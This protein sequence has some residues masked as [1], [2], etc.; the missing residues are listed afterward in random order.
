MS[1]S[2]ITAPSHRLASAER[3]L[4]HDWLA[5]RFESKEKEARERVEV[6]RRF[7]LKDTS[8]MPVEVSR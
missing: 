4:G 8:Q 6:I 7:L 5:K 2:V 3:A 1:I